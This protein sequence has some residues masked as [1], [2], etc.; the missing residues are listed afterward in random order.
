METLT[1]F[2]CLSGAIFLVALLMISFS[3]RIVPNGR[4]MA[5]YRL[6]EYLGDKGP[7]IVILIPFIDRGVMKISDRTDEIAN[8][9]E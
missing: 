7:G 4:R 6:G 8:R 2:L 1:V 3:I 9:D 5:V